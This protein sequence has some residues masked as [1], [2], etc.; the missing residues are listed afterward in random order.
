[1]NIKI[2][3]V[4][5]LQTNCYILTINNNSLIIDPGDES[6]KI[7]NEIA[8]NNVL[9]ILIT[10]SHFDHIGALNELISKYNAPVYCK[11]NLEEKEY[12]I[13]KF[14]FS[15]IYT[16][17]HT[18]DSISFYFKEDNIMFT[19]DFLFKGTIGR[20]DLPTGND[21][22][23]WESIK[24]I[25]MYHPHIRIFPGHGEDSTLEQEFMY[26]IYLQNR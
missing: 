23:M 21:K 11:E 15:V 8:N 17:G 26:N 9:G 10:H 13:A 16:P 24:K 6:E 5:S 4:G 22:K 18:D 25:K 12:Q 19:G 14:K 7:I 1:M 3:K 2:I 20:T